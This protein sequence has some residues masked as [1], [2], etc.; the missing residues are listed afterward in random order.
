MKILLII[1]LILGAI[2]FLVLGVDAQYGAGGFSLALRIGPLSVRLFPQKKDV[3]RQRKPSK[4]KES[5]NKD[6]AS[7]EQQEAGFLD[8]DLIMK[9]IPL[10]LETLGKFRR[11]LTVDLLAIHFVAAKGDP[12]DTMM[13]YGRVNAVLYTVLPLLNDCL[14][15]R[16]QDIRTDFS[17]D[18][19]KPEIFSHLIVSVAIWE[20]LYIGL[21]F[22]FGFLKIYLS[23]KKQKKHE[24][25]SE[26]EVARSTS[27]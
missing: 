1:L 25:E 9:M 16:E 8:R 23:Q 18:A 11:K 7:E 27:A 13:Q 21:S 22:G 26:P 4:R 3:A 15:I 12:Y 20:M 24:V 10:G 14:N 2:V 17:F 6:K 5:K 19:E